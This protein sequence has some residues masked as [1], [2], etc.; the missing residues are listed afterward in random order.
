MEVD[1]LY[2]ILNQ[3]VNLLKIMLKHREWRKF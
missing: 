2:D 1:M 3:S